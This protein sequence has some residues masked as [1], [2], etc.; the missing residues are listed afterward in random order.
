VVGEGLASSPRIIKSTSGESL[1]F[2][3]SF[4]T[5]EKS[6]RGED[7]IYRPFNP[8]QRFKRNRVAR[9]AAEK[10]ILPTPLSVQPLVPK[11]VLTVT[12]NNWNIV[13]GQELH[14]E[15]NYLRGLTNDVV[16]LI[17]LYIFY[18]VFLHKCLKGL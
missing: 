17:F 3:G 9:L 13:Y 11:T 7:D 1:K 18:N 10:R 5:V 14:N 2:V 4:D 16:F 15:A 6:V 8:A 12:S